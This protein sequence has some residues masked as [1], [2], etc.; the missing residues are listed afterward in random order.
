MHM[1]KWH[2]CYLL[3][4]T[5]SRCFVAPAACPSN[6]CSRTDHRQLL[7]RL[8]ALCCCADKSLFVSQYISLTSD[9][10][11]LTPELQIV[12][13]A[14]IDVTWRYAL[15]CYA[16]ASQLLPIALTMVCWDELGTVASNPGQLLVVLLCA[17]PAVSAALDAGR[18]QLDAH[19]RLM[20]N[21]CSPSA[22]GGRVNCCL[23]TWSGLHFG[24][25]PR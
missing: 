24:K 5:L 16:A 12:T 3:K 22:D 1:L 10:Q 2:L 25:D 4:L 8:A 6:S 19:G 23:C 11:H 15:S 14:F 7:D 9:E 17:T 21:V 18:T 13:P 20:T